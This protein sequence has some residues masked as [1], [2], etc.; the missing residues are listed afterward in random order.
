MRRDI[1]LLSG[2]CPGMLLGSMQ[3]GPHANAVAAL[4]WTMVTE[5]PG[6]VMEVLPVLARVPAA[7]YYIYIHA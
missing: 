4:T 7:Y 5:V 6:Q 3:A 2:V 1:Q